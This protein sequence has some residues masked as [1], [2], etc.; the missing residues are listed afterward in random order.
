MC[1]NDCHDMILA[2][3]VALDLGTANQLNET[4]LISTHSIGFGKEVMDLE[5]IQ[6]LFFGAVAQ[7]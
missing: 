5:Y 4:I 6:C 7:Y 1:V 2:V 3:K